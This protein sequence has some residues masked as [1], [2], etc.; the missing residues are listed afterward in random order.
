M[1]AMNAWTLSQTH[2]LALFV[3]K[4][5]KKQTNQGAR[6]DTPD[7]TQPPGSFR[8]AVPLFLQHSFAVQK[9]NE[10]KRNETKT[11]PISVVGGA[12]FS[13]PASTSHPSF[14]SLRRVSPTPTS[15]SR[16]IEPLLPTGRGRARLCAVGRW[17]FSF[18]VP[19]G[20][21]KEKGKV[22]G[23]VLRG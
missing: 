2:L 18:R 12:R 10:T 8:K 23:E 16:S 9:R 7:P 14:R 6:T 5:K 17:F 1:H 3:K 19:D 11:L 15:R 4:N 13:F 20:S 22:R 21:R